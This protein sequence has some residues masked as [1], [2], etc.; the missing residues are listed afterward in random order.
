M[1]TEQQNP[2]FREAPV[3]DDV[4]DLSEYLGLLLENRYL[5]AGIT[6]LFFLVAVVYAILATPIYRADAMLQ[7][8]GE[9]SSKSLD[10]LDTLMGS[11]SSSADTEIEIIKSRTVIGAVVD[12]LNLVTVGQPKTFPLIGDFFYRR[13]AAAT[14][15]VDPLIGLESYAWGGEQIRVERFDVPDG[16]V[17]ETFTLRSSG[18]GAYGLLDEA[19]NSVLSG[20]V[21]K[22]ASAGQI[23]L[24]ISVLH[25]RPGTRFKLVR[26]S[27]NGVIDG[28]RS[29]IK[30]SE[31]GKK[32]GIITINYEGSDREQI[33]AVVN[34]LSQSYLRQNVERKS[35]ESEKMLAFIEQQMPLL[36]TELNAA[37]M[38]LNRY[39]EEQGTVDLSIESQAL[40]ERVT[41]IASELSQLRLERSELIQKLTEDHPIIHGI[42]E[43]MKNL[44]EQRREIEEKMQT[45]PATELESV[46]LSRDVT[47]ANELYMLLLNRAQE[48]KVT[49][50]GTIGNARIIDEAVVQSLPVKPKRS[51]IVAVSLLLGFIVAVVLVVLRRALNKKIEDPAVVEQQLGYP[52]YAEIPY[53]EVQGQQD[54]E[55]KKRLQES[56]PQLMAQSDGDTHVIESLRSLRTSIQ[57]ALMEAENNLITISGPA[58][59]VGK[60]FISANFAYLMAE[61]GKK[62]LLID[63]DMRKGHLATYFGM[64]RQPGLSETLS[65]ES[66]FDA[67]VHR[68]ALHENLDLLSCG[69]YPPNPS[70][71][72]MSEAFKS[73]LHK[74]GEQYDL[75]LIDTPPVLAVTD[76]VIIGQYTGT[77]FMVLRSGQ[78][79]LREIQTALRRFEQNGVHIKGTIFN[80]V[81]VMKGGLAGKYGYGYKYYAY[82]YNYKS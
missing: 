40:I 53:S 22:V 52:N 65:G 4:I 60:S 47:V 77:N 23:E 3:D 66:D 24:F 25:A 64:A 6:A 51:L 21:G 56:L 7:I 31:K 18:N 78:H 13:N 73:L 70:E 50:A 74:V 10:Q 38:A 67:A 1:S 32:T 79:H 20:Q 8:E 55:R 15:P 14:E 71:L 59:E 28:L 42:D 36:K 58:P 5:I 11:E 80:G 30:V 34:A 63:A 57:F 41:R 62:I 12:R 35:A 45:L 61:A 76:P 69:V 72:L 46:K 9:S 39:R 33:R 19:G 37:E 81:E 75:V 49:K 43:K 2:N 27:R 44:A 29:A 54:R 17:G 26:Q 48:L 16:M 82:Q 68:G